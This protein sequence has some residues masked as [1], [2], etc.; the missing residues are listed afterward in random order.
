MKPPRLVKGDTVGII[1]PASPLPQ[2]EYLS[3]GIQF[4]Q[5]LGYRVRTSSN[6]KQAGSY[7]GYLAA[8]DA[9]RLADL[10]Q[11]FCDPEIKALICL[12]GG[13]GS[14]R[15]LDSINYDLIRSH[16][17]ILVGYSDI[18]ALH[19]ALQRMTGLV[20]F[21]GPM[22]YPELGS[23]RVV[24]YTQASLLKSLTAAESIGKI[25][26]LTE[27]P[28]AFTITPG[29]AQGKVTGGNLS[30]VVAT[31]GTPYEI[32]T[33]DKIL[34]LEE[35]GEAPYRLDRMLTQLALAGKLKT[36]AGIC[37]GHCTGCGDLEQENN[38]LNVI[39][40]HLA[41]LG[42][43]CC[44]GLPAGHLAIQATL[45]LGLE[46]YLDADSCSLV[47]LEAATV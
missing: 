43:P 20:T 41:P 47:Y 38:F 42:L 26:P 13:Y 34:F 27:L 39:I 1:A 22:I 36:A 15:L 4:W 31:L 29:Q 16:P 44:Y 6:I 46:A 40:N 28:A 30:L 11:M 14:L 12:R 8:N 24:P 3:R 32:D 35:V 10:Q 33:R 9:E 18:T 19:L 21:H 45:P 2:I 17:K 37:F 23:N 5:K 7:H 25:E